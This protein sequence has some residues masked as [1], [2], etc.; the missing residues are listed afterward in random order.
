MAV[1]LG[2]VPVWNDP[3]PWPPDVAGD[4]H[5]NRSDVEQAVLRAQ[6]YFNTITPTGPDDIIVISTGTN[7][8]FWVGADGAGAGCAYHLSVAVGRGQ[9]NAVY[10]DV[11]YPGDVV[12]PA[13]WAGGVCGGTASRPFAGDW[14]SQAAYHEIAEAS[15]DPQGHGWYDD[16]IAGPNEIG[17]IYGAPATWTRLSLESY[18][19]GST[20]T[21][22]IQPLFSN[23]SNNNLGAAVFADR[24][25]Y[26]LNDP[27]TREWFTSSGNLYGLEKFPYNTSPVVYWDADNTASSPGVAFETPGVADVAYFG[28]DGLLWVRSDPPYWAGPLQPLD[29]GWS[30]QSRPDLASWGWGHID[31]YALASLAGCSVPP[32]HKVRHHFKSASDGGWL[33]PDDIYLPGG[34]EIASGPGAASNAIGEVTLAVL[35]QVGN[36]WVGLSTDASG[37]NFSWINVNVSLVPPPAGVSMIGDP[38]VSAPSGNGNVYDVWLHDSTGQLWRFFW[39]HGSD[40]WMPFGMPLDSR[41]NPV[42]INAVSATSYG[43]DD[44]MVV[45]TDAFGNAYWGG[46][47]NG[48]WVGFLPETG[49]AAGFNTRVETACY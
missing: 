41:G 25:W 37:T 30:Y 1:G 6:A 45:V 14:P 4:H 49:F 3:T 48:V 17:D 13:R 44:T 16:S 23:E 22:T 12:S 28:P 2:S 9:P 11:P 5:P 35:D 46:F 10:A 36:L 47:V 43:D 26:I 39:N 19:T 32:C 40:G 33:A 24:G 7:R 27:L 18:P 8:T 38:D 15:T 31:A 42:P 29:A 20:A 34:A 21:F